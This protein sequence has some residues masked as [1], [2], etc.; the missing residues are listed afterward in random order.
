VLASVHQHT[1]L[2]LDSVWDVKPMTYT[3][4]KTNRLS[5]FKAEKLVREDLN[6]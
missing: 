4:M 6:V 5:A 2:V 1:Q 3:S